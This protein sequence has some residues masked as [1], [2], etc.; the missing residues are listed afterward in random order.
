MIFIGFIYIN[1]KQYR[2]CPYCK[3]G[4]WKSFDVDSGGSTGY[5]CTNCHE[6]T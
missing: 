2:I 4:N 3:K 1:I 5:K 6:L